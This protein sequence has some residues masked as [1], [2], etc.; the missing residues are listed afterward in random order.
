MTVFIG[1]IGKTVCIDS[2]YCYSICKWTGLV[3]YAC[4]ENC[5][6]R[7]TSDWLDNCTQNSSLLCE[8]CFCQKSFTA[9]Y[10]RCH[11]YVDYL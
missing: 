9:Y 2:T 6:A 4:F 5:L 1:N 7:H 8:L 3:L 10:N 11:L